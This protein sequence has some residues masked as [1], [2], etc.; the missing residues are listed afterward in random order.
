MYLYN[1]GLSSIASALPGDVIISLHDMITAHM[2][3]VAPMARP[4]SIRQYQSPYRAL[5]PIGTCG[6]IAYRDQD[7]RVGL[8]FLHG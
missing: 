5:L 1:T 2:S 7:H 4:D 3:G 6:M 8:L